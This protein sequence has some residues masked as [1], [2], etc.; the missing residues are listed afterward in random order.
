MQSPS[1]Q[2]WREEEYQPPPRSILYSLDPISQQG[3]GAESLRSYFIRLC[4]AHGVT[5]RR[6]VREVLASGAPGFRSYAG[7]RFLA[8]GAMTINGLGSVAEAFAARLEALCARRDLTPLTLN[9]W[10]VLLPSNSAGAVY[11][12]PRWC[13]LCIAEGRKTEAEIHQPLVWSM[14]VVA[15][16]PVHHTPLEHSCGSCGRRQPALPRIPDLGRCAHCGEWLDRSHTAKPGN[17]SDVQRWVAAASVEMTLAG[18]PVPGIQPLSRFRTLLLKAIDTYAGGVRAHFCRQIGLSPWALTKWLGEGRRP[19]L[20]QLLHVAYALDF[21][22]AALFRLPSGQTPDFNI[23]ALPGKLF[24]RAPKPL[25]SPDDVRRLK[26]S[27]QAAGEQGLTVSSICRQESLKR[28]AI[29]YWL[30]EECAH[31]SKLAKVAA[32]SAS[33]RSRS[34]KE[35]L[36]HAA[37]KQIAGEGAYPS[38][39]RMEDKLKQSGTSLLNGVAREAYAQDRALLIGDCDVSMANVNLDQK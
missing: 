7:S 20:P 39:R 8:T 18:F 23:R 15:V 32:E 17:A 38:R 11:R 37:F 1:L 25:L 30:P 29:K 13:P 34:E 28:S 5:P 31:T 27:L 12:K 35:D 24:H 33:K 3:L 26:L 9:P 10:A 2:S 4:R 22:P 6:M 21:Q 19:S 16:C 36:A 14:A